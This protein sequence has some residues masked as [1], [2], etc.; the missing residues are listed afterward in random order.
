MGSCYGDRIWL[1]LQ[2]PL[3][4]DM[5]T[6][7]GQFLNFFWLRW[8]FL[9]VFH[10]FLIW[11]FFVKRLNFSFVFH[12]VF[13]CLCVCIAWKG[14]PQND[15]YCVGREL[16][17]THPLITACHRLM[18]EVERLRG[19]LEESS[20]KLQELISVNQQLDADCCQLITEKRVLQMR[21]GAIEDASLNDSCDDAKV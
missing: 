14:R 7:N 5:H 13:V 3:L 11:F 9:C 1:L 4:L 16:N 10:V 19:Q 6:N 15:L 2:L 8:I 12:Y 17:A 20:H 21:L 18:Q